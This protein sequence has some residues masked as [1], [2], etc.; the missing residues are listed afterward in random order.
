MKRTLIATAIFLLPMTAVWADDPYKN[1][2]EPN[3]KYK[4]G[5]GV[6]Y[7]YD[8]SKPSDKVRYEVDPAAK[9]RDSLIVDP[10]VKLDRDRG[11]SGGGA[12]R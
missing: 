2:G 1:N 10:R 9:L 11:Q 12:R 8:L 4:S 6:E 7:Q 5:T 3:Y